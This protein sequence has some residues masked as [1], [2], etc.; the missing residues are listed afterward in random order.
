MDWLGLAYGSRIELWHLLLGALVLFFLGW[1][2]EYVTEQKERRPDGPATRTRRTTLSEYLYLMELMA[3]KQRRPHGPAT[4]T[5]RT[6][7]SEYVMEQKERTRVCPERKCRHENPRHAVY[8]A[9][10]GRKLRRKRR[11][12]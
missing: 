5:R 11:T 3:P 9:R 6:T 12:W 10:C 7:L 8:C 1:L 2:G 4:R